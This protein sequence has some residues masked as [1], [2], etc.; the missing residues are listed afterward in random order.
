MWDVYLPEIKDLLLI[1]RDCILPTNGKD[2]KWEKISFLFW[3]K[4]GQEKVLISSISA[5]VLW[6][7][8]PSSYRSLALIARS[9]KLELK[10][11]RKKGSLF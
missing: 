11:T 7:D 10:L 4:V 1:L 6:F 3:E 8:H 2:E 9:H 5:L